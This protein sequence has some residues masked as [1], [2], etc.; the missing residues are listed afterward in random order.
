MRRREFITLLGGAATGLPR[1]A[2]AQQPGLLI[3]MLHSQTQESEAARLPAIQQGLRETGFEV[4][5]NVS[6]EHRYADGHNDRLPALAAELVRRRVNVIFANTTP[7]ATAAKA[8]TATIPVVFITGVDPV[9]V[10]LVASM[11]RPG[12]NVTGVTFLSNK[13]V[14]K[15]LELLADLTPRDGAIGM[16]A[17]QKNPNTEADVRDAL[18]AAKALGRTLHVVKV[19]PEGDI[20]EAVDALVQQRVGALFVAPQADFRMWRQQ[21]VLLAARHTLPTSFSSSDHVAGGALMSYGPD[22]MESYRQAAVYAGRILKGETPASLPVMQSTKFEFAINLK[23]ARALGIAIP[24]PM[25][26]LATN[27][28]E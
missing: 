7:P 2:D 28:V 9:E 18:A 4:G 20:N 13:L 24:A 11:N 17:A 25:L 12:G 26:A 3:G 8:A 16:L 22:Q 27:V 15:R 5:R 6:I 14:A 19:A 1:T 23:T 10:G 21:L